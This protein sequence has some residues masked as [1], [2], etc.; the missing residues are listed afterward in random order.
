MKIRPSIFLTAD[1]HFGHQRIEDWC[2]RKKSH[3][4]DMV[5]KWNSVIKKQDVVLHLG[6][7]TMTN[8]E[9]T[10]GWTK[11]LKGRKYLI[12]GNHDGN[13]VSWYADC[14]FTVIP[15]SLYFI[16]DKYENKTYVCF[17]HEPIVPL[18]KGWFNIHGHL[19][20]DDHRGIETSDSHFDVGVDSMGYK[21]IPLYDLLAQIKK[22][23]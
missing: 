1:T 9:T 5:R 18:P 4:E 10:I 12:R 14:G 23:M 3:N 20:G 6:D 8:K 13:S 19:H 21:P 16:M 17:T 15:P 22:K 7:L 2:E 11:R